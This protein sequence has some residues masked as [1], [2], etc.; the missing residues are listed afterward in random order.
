MHTVPRPPRLTRLLVSVLLR[1]DASE[2][3]LGDLD[4][5]FTRAIDADAAP[6]RARRRYR[7]QALKS[8][9][10]CLLAW[11]A[12]SQNAGTD[13]RTETR[14]ALRTI[15][16]G[17]GADVRF[18]LRLFRREKASVGAVVA[19]LTVAIGLCTALFA[20]MNALLFR[21]LDVED[22]ASLRWVRKTGGSPTNLGIAGGDGSAGVVVFPAW[23]SG[24]LA[25]LRDH[26]TSARI[27]GVRQS[28]A[29]LET[30]DGVF[31]T[32]APIWFVSPDFFAMT[33][34]R[35]A[36]GR[37]LGPADDAQAT[38]API[39]IN[40]AF[41][42]RRLGARSDIVG[43]TVRLNGRPFTVVGIAARRYMGPTQDPPAFWAPLAIYDLDWRDGARLG[44]GDEVGWTLL[45]K[46]MPGSTTGRV[47]AELSA[48]MRGLRPASGVEAGESMVEV[49]AL[50]AEWR[51]LNGAVISTAVL[52]LLGFVLL[53]GCG[54]VANLLVASA[55][56]RQAEIG[57]RLALGASR[58]RIVRQILTESAVLGLAGAAGGLLAAIW[59]TP[60]VAGIA[61]VR[62]TFDLSPD[63]RT[64]T[65][66]ALA[67]VVT[68]LAAGL[69]PARYGARGDLRS[70]LGTDPARAP[71]ATGRFGNVVIAVQAAI[72]MLML[73]LGA[74]LTR[75]AWRA[76]SIDIGF[77]ADRLLQVM[78]PVTANTGRS[79]GQGIQ[80]LGA[81]RLRRLPSVER[82]AQSRNAPLSGSYHALG[83]AEDRRYRAYVKEVSPEYFSALGIPILEGRG[84]DATEAAAGAPA[85]IIAA[86]LA[87]D[88]WPGGSPVGDR[89][90][91]VHRALA[92]VQVIGVAGD[93]LPY[94][95]LDAGHD[96]TAIYR[97]LA[98]NDTGIRMLVVRTRGEAPAAVADVRAALAGLDPRARPSISLTRDVVEAQIRGAAVPSKIAT[99]AIAA[100]L[101]L[102]AIGVYGLSTFTVGRR[103]REIAVR[104]ALGASRRAV[105][106]R[107]LADGFR[108]IVIGLAIGLV[109]AW[110][111]GRW[112]A[113]I[114]LGVPALDPWS[115]AVALGALLGVT[116]GS[117][118]LPAR[119]STALDPAAVLRQQ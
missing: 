14:S 37:L 2:I 103:R 59:L 116:G 12:E 110:L 31:E 115:V 19:G 112:L 17:L 13:G 5:E 56:T 101:A 83:L 23:T 16:P 25:H 7:K 69:A 119:R 70:A 114:L 68:G 55:A 57:V 40:H 97:A 39:V 72:A 21:T 62:S 35:A 64:Y 54:N 95:L 111:A 36:A 52:L 24:D 78:W 80:D 27:A 117:M 85:A 108:P 74:S 42:T 81:E 113:A 61:N 28:A 100:I 73:V 11:R 20:V 49:T 60:M 109:M 4:E 18:A 44:A 29:R 34:A 105:V 76:S 92:G 99:L 84:F 89:L 96:T 98:R 1:A 65:F 51:V 118:V 9:A 104:L 75:G 48:L 86:R 3:V 93:V 66:V 22:A 38:S 106:R 87:R 8:I 43:T 77:D 50:E 102:A 107:V 90:D 82:V 94:S 47:Q 45:A 32:Q 71:A 91:R 53:L 15:V 46:L 10:S 6:R 67:A 30:D 58:G 63:A 33:G 88:F 41:W 26:A 79:P